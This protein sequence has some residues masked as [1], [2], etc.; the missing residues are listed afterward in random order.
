VAGIIT[1]DGIWQSHNFH[2]DGDQDW[3]EFTATAGITYTLTTINTGGHADTVLYLYE[4]DGSTLID[5][6]D[7]DPDNWP[8]SRLEWG[9][10]R[11]G[12]YYVQVEHW[13][14]YAYGCTTDYGLSIAETGTFE[15]SNN[16]Y[17]PVIL[18][19]AP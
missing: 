1:T 13:D 8:A 17:L 5:S 2:I 6:N 9:A 4:S 7:D 14:P 3:V 15:V 12:I 11:S 10:T 19:N 18:R 16:V